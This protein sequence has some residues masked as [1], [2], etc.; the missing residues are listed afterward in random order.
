[1]LKAIALGMDP[2]KAATATMAELGMFLAIA[3]RNRKDSAK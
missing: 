3:K 2:T 1:M